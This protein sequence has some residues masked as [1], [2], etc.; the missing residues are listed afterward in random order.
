MGFWWLLLCLLEPEPEDDII[1][2][3]VSAIPDEA[4]PELKRP[5]KIET[6]FYQ[7]SAE[8]HSNDL[9]KL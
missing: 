3:E 7:V 4:N 8:C 1:M 9:S 5:T 6:L 2:A